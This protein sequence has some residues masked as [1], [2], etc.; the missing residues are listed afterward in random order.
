MS[1]ETKSWFQRTEGKFGTGLTLALLAGGGIT[2]IYFWGLILPW[3][4]GIVSGTAT[5]IALCAAIAVPIVLIS[6]SRTRRLFFYGYK[7]LMRM[8]TGLFV[9]IDPIGILQTYA[10]TLREKLREMTQSIEALAG[11]QKKLKIQINAQETERVRNLKLAG[12]ANKHEEMKGSFIVYSR[13]AGRLEKSNIALQELYDRMDKLLK[14]LVKMR[15]TSSVLVQD[16]ENEVNLKVSEHKALKAGYNAFSKAKRIMDS[17]NEDKEL[18]DSAL[19]NLADTYGMQMGEIELFMDMNKNILDGVDLENEVHV[20]DA[21][22]KLAEWER[23]SSADKGKGP[24]FRVDNTP[25]TRVSSAVDNSFSDLFES[26]SDTDVN[27][28]Q[29]K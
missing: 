1:N 22:E 9:T 17:N 26:P 23:K 10:E 11:Q 8:I 21:L 7:S 18:Y 5:L 27:Q 6:D 25:P 13:Q 29:G 12:E 16:I 20:Q 4:L 2:V 19:D 24:Q 14:V 3:L 28:Q 15:E